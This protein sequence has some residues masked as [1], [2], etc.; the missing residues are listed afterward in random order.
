MG[1][2]VPIALARSFKGIGE[3]SGVMALT[4]FSVLEY[5]EHRERG[6]W[7]WRVGLRAGWVAS[8]IHESEA[9]SHSF[10]KQHRQDDCNH[11]CF[12]DLGRGE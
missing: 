9:S 5:L 4:P 6:L 7:G 10:L 1:C 12:L 11:M 2:A 3:S 8:N